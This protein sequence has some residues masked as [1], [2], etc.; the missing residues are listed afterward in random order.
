M[1]TGGP[2]GY[3]F[4]MMTSSNENIFRVAGHLCGEFTG[5][6]IS[7]RF[8]PKGP[9]NNELELVQITAW[10]LLP[11]PMVTQ[12]PDEATTKQWLVTSG[13]VWTH[14]KPFKTLASFFYFGHFVD[15]FGTFKHILSVNH[16]IASVLAK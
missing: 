3:V 1:A 15:A 6:Q 5:P 4:N 14:T 12:M 16:M 7:S 11:A 2:R 9:A 10:R 13:L 8:I